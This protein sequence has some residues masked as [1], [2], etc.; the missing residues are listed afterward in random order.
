MSLEKKNRLRIISSTETEMKTTD[1][2]AE[3]LEES[4]YEQMLQGY[5]NRL[6]SRA[7]K[8]T[9]LS[10]EICVINNFFEYTNLYPW[11]WSS[12]D[13]EE[14]SAY[15]YS[16]KNNCEATQRHKQRIIARFQ[17]YIV[18]SSVF[19]EMCFKN[20]GKKPAL[21]CSAVNLIPHK[22]DDE[23]KEKRTAFTKDQIRILWNYFD[24]QIYLAF[25]NKTKNLKIL[26]RDK[27][28]Y[29]TIYYYGLRAN[30][31]SM[32]DTTDFTNNPN[33]PIWGEFGG[34]VVRF[35][36]SSSGSPPKRR[37]VWTISDESVQCLKWYFENVRPQF[38]FDDSNNLFVSERGVRLSPKSITRN[39]KEYL[40]S[41]G[42]QNHNYSTHCLR[43]SYISH[44]SENTYVSPRFIQEQVGHSYLATTQ[45]YTHLSDIFIRNQLNKV[46]EKQVSKL[47]EKE[48]I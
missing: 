36:K 33:K 25:K 39:F 42:L 14:W 44:L 23:N 5:K 2:K 34:I 24:E 32:L 30:E 12:D 1:S 45:L 6:M 8:P 46:T 41:A 26:Q 17:S 27:A 37:I 19:N 10:N 15:L 40:K 13:F 11:E 43:H 22:V 3:Y 9:T 7:L 35:G 28:L 20:F 29:M 38:R 21:I 4:I 47:L 16:V 31:A 18:D 48:N